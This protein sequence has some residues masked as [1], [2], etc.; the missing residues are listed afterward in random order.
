MEHFRE[1]QDGI[2]LLR[3]PFPPVWSGVTLVRGEELCLIDSG[4]SADVVDG[5]I[6]PALAELGLGLG[7][8]DWLVNTHCHGDHIGGHARIKELA[9]Q[10]RTACI[11]QAAPA[12]RDPA[13][14]AVRI[15]TKYPR[16]SPPPQCYLRGVEPDRFLRDG[17]ALG[18]RLT[19]L[20]TPGHDGDCVCW[21]DRKT[22]TAVTG[23]SLQANGT[24]TQGI[25]FYQDLDAYLG[26]V[27]KLRTCDVENIIAGHDYAGMGYN[28]EGA[29]NVR[30]VLD[31]CAAY[32]EQYQRFV[33]EALSC[34]LT[35]TSVMAA[36]M[37]TQ[38][39]CGMPQKLFLA[40]YTT[41]EHIRHS[42]FYKGELK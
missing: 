6:R 1:V 40:M 10:I 12:L 30:R 31:L 42:K 5:V 7:D 3:S 9:P 23:D 34:G 18:D 4:A 16:F 19:V 39:G 13:A 17:E 15:R 36:Q 25:A 14:N 32:T 2:F 28:I 11:E 27:A 38:L 20:H 22:K 24:V 35:D 21:Y 41:D 33:D 8:I 37:I 29:E 26:S